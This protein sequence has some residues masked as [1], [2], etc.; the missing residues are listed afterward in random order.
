MITA[1]ISKLVKSKVWFI[2]ET[3]DDIYMLGQ[4]AAVLK[5]SEKGLTLEGKISVGVDIQELLSK[6]IEE[7]FVPEY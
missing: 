3:A 4:L 1:N 2:T 5:T 6:T 7:K